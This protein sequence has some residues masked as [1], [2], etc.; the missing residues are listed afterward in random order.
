VRKTLLSLMLAVLMLLT[1]LGSARPGRG[2]AAAPKKGDVRVNPRDGLRYVWIPPGKFRMG[3]SPGDTLCKDNEEPAH[4]VTLT[5]GFWIGQTEV[6]VGAYRRYVRST[7]KQMPRT[8]DEFG[9]KLN[10]ALGS[11]KVPVVAVSWEDANA[12]CEWAGVKLPTEA[13]WEYAARGGS[14]APRYGELDKIAWYADNSGR[15]RIDS[16]AWVKQYPENYRKKIFKNGNGPHPV[17]R[18]LKNG[19]NLYDTLGNAW[20]WVSDWYD[21]RYYQAQASENPQG[22]REGTSRVVRGLC[23]D[24]SRNT[25]RVSFRYGFP[26]ESRITVVGFRCAGREIH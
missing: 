3:C 18:K 9:T 8:G 5:E 6:T 15:S 24:D 7:G 4:E 25:V 19:F 1:L 11:E 20:E 21:E 2:H 26:P 14:S 13:E 23:W 17:S 12:Y 22:P 10:E 16:T